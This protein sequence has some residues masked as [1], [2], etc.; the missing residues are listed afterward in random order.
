M[1][2]PRK[3]S[4]QALA[5]LAQRAKHA[6]LSTPRDPLKEQPQHEWDHD[7][8]EV[9]VPIPEGS[10]PAAVRRRAGDIVLRELSFFPAWMLAHKHDDIVA[11][12]APLLGVWG[13]FADRIIDSYERAQDDI[14]VF[15]LGFTYATVQGHFET[16]IESFRASRMGKDAPVLFQVE[17]ISRPTNPLKWIISRA[18]VRGLQRRFGADV[19][20][21]FRRLLRDKFHD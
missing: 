9:P 4:P 13:V 12:A 16:G 3:P 6:P 17:A 18:F 5:R 2:T 11:V 21:N 19:T 14:G 20:E 8:Y 15:D 1:Y 7:R 10:D